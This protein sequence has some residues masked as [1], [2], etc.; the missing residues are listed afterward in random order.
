MG[1]IRKSPTAYTRNRNDSARNAITAAQVIAMTN[2]YMLPHGTRC[3]A[4]PRVT[5]PRIWVARPITVS[6]SA[7][8]IHGPAGAPPARQR[9]GAATAGPAPPPAA[10]WAAAPACP[11]SPVSVAGAAISGAVAAIWAA[12]P[13]PTATLGWGGG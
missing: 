10:P 7:A 3:S 5:M 11:A 4:M 1:A 6:A 13:A 12:T 8:R 2:S 9:L